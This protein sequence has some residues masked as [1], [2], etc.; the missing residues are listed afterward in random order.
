[1]IIPAVWWII[2]TAAG[3]LSCTVYQCIAYLQIPEYLL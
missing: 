2:P 1:M 3:P